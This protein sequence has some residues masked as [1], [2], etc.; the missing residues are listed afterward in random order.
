MTSTPEPPEA[1]EPLA[2]DHPLTRMVRGRS[3]MAALMRQ[4]L[5]R[6]ADNVD[7]DEL[8]TKLRATANGE[9]SLRDLVADESFGAAAAQG[10]DKLGEEQADADPEELAEQQAETDQILSEQP[11]P[12]GPE[13]PDLPDLWYSVPREQARQMA[14]DFVNANLTKQRPGRPRE[15]S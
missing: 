11:L 10:L 7:D 2:D 6:A 3:A 15:G 9:L 1:P 14:R 8:A 4:G 5:E 12:E 13:L